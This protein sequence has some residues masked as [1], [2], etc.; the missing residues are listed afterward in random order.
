M[1]RKHDNGWWKIADEAIKWGIWFETV[2]G[3]NGR[4][5]FE[6]HLIGDSVGLG[7]KVHFAKGKKEAMAFLRGV[8]VGTKETK[9]LWR[10]W[11]EAFERDTGIKL[12][13]EGG[14]EQ[15]K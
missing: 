12:S 11:K 15:A 14:D 3:K 2:I 13:S 1:S 5:Q 9:K 8:E 10:R 6:F 4:R 7:E